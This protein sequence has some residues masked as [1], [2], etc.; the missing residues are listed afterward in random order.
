MFHLLV[1]GP[2]GTEKKCLP[3]VMCALSVQDLKVN[4]TVWKDED[5]FSKS[6]QK[7]LRQENYN[8]NSSE[9]ILF[10]FV[11]IIN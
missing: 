3:A 6:S 8:I 4:N 5:G 11:P 9:H 10:I 2:S 1:N 7:T